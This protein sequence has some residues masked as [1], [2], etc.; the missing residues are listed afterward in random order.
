VFS[1]GYL[2]LNFA[3]N[4][5]EN[6]SA[7]RQWRNMALYYAACRGTGKGSVRVAPITGE[8]LVRYN[9][10]KQDQINLSKGLAYLGL[11]M[12]ASGARKLYPALRSIASLNSPNECR[13]LLHSPIP[14]SAMSLSTV[15]SFSTCPMGDNM[16]LCAADSYGRV[17]GFENLYIA[18]ASLIPDSPGV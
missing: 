9:L 8:A 10:S 3:E 16:D 13:E 5:Q 4:W 1:P 17:H 7:M 11:A 15:H 6:S 14:I 2:A 12:F 18:D